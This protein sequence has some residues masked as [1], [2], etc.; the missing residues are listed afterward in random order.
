MPWGP[1]QGLFQAASEILHQGPERETGTQLYLGTEE[2]APRYWSAREVKARHGL[3]ARQV[4]C[5]ILQD[6][7]AEQIGSTTSWTWKIRLGWTFHPW[8]FPLGGGK[9]IMTPPCTKR[10]KR[11][12]IYTAAQGCPSAWDAISAF[13]R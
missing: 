10:S 1:R 6:V 12:S 2:Q 4:R 7:M 3:V 9:K 13:C 5:D 8:E 11:V